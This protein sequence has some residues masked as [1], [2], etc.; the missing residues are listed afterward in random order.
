MFYGCAQSTSRSREE[1]S[2]IKCGSLQK[3]KGLKITRDVAHI[4]LTFYHAYEI[5][6]LAFCCL[7]FCCD[8][9]IQ[10]IVNVTHLLTFVH[11]SS[12]MCCIC[13]QK[14]IQNYILKKS[15]IQ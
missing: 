7:T 4:I 6:N 9:R 10:Q 13:F 15:K 8:S 11:V 12:L 2:L 5:R 1:R 3:G 14:E